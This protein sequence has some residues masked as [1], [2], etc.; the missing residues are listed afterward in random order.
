MCV[1][2]TALVF[3][4]LEDLVVFRLDR[5]PANLSM[6]ESSK[7]KELEKS[8]EE[9]TTGCAH[10]A[11]VIRMLAGFFAAHVAEVFPV[12]AEL[13]LWHHRLLEAPSLIP[14]SIQTP[15]GGCGVEPG[16]R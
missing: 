3:F 5:A 7:E 16:E 2:Q 15:H 14:F 10:L 1:H 6:N 4:A 8:P 12:R 13:L 9:R 11:A